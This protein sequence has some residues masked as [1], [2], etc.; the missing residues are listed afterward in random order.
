M[1]TYGIQ[2]TDDQPA[3]LPPGCVPAK[4]K[5]RK[6]REGRLLKRKSRETQDVM[7]KSRNTTI[8]TR[9]ARNNFLPG[10]MKQ[11]TH[12]VKIT[13]DGEKRKSWHLPPHFRWKKLW[14][15]AVCNTR[16]TPSSNTRRPVIFRRC[17]PPIPPQENCALYL[18]PPYAARSTNHLPARPHHC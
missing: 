3:L 15:P 14:P 1:K 13:S 2:P 16:F 12:R 11:K 5:T 18:P 8:S 10:R 6:A 17:P 4:A 9:R 7:D